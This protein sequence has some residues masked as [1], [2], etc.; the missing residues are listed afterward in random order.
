MST[1]LPKHSASKPAFPEGILSLQ[2][3]HSLAFHSPYYVKRYLGYFLGRWRDLTVKTKC[4]FQPAEPSDGHR[5]L[6][7]RFYPRGIHR[8][9][10]DDWVFALSPSSQLLFQ[11]KEGK[12]SWDAFKTSFLVQ[13]RNEVEGLEAI[14]ALHDWSRHHDITLLCYEK[15]GQPCHRH[16][17]RE[18]ID[19]PSL[20]GVTFE[21]KQTNDHE[22]IAKQHHVSHQETPL[23]VS[24]R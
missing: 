20:L 11:Y 10:F 21:A 8:S 22:R 9:H 5:V 17:V 7:T 18:V 15:S 13:L 23:V 14:D 12:V 24:V 3:R 19:N 6:I 16:L 1:T 4:I 2:F